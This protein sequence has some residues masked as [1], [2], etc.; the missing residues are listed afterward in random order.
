MPIS[1][2]ATETI[3]SS[4]D[5]VTSDPKSGLQGLV[6]VS[7]DKKGETLVSHAS[8]KRALNSDDPMTM[9]TVFWI[10]SCTKNIASI[11]CMQLVEQGKL[12]LDDPNALYKLCPEIEKVKVLQDGKLVD[13]KGDIT[14]RMLLSH[15]AGYGY[16]FFNQRLTDYGRAGGNGVKGAGYEVFSGDERD[17]LNQPLVNQPGTAWEYGINVDW[18]GI[19]LERATGMTLNDYCQ[20]N[21]FEP[22][23]LKNISFFPSQH[24]R[25]NITTMLQRAPSGETTERDHLYRRALLAST[26]H[27]KKHIFNS[28]GAGAFAKPAEY[29]Q[30]LAALLN[31]GTSPTTGHQLLKKETI[32]IMW[33]NQIPQYPDFARQ[34]LQPANPTLANP[35]PEFYP[36]GGNPPQGWGLSFFLTIQKGET[37]RGGN[38]AWWA[39]ISNQF[40]WCDRERGVAGMMCGQILPFGDERVLGQWVACEKAVYDGLEG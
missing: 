30:I 16:E 29:C 27:E 5:S 15:T 35:A 22:L 8:G 9:D 39:G 12:S 26:E 6:F 40:W 13:R 7:V 37:G 28:G 31:D 18:A 1:A 14:L 38:T 11:A 4:L 23:G 21:I 10:A 3:K 19:A 2:Q 20:K 32:D 17:I 25:D 33:E 34:N 36:Q 24:M